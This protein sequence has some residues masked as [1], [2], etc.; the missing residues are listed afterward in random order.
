MI[1]RDENDR[2]QPR[3]EPA[4]TCAQPIDMVCGSVRPFRRSDWVMVGRYDFG[5]KRTEALD[6]VFPAHVINITTEGH[7]YFHGRSGRAQALP[8]TVTLGSCGD[9]YSC[10]H[11]RSH[12]NAN[13]VLA[14]S[15][16]AVDAD[17]GPIFERQVIEVPTLASIVHRALASDGDDEF[18]SRAFE[19]FDWVST[20]SQSPSKRRRKGVL[21]MQRVK[22]FLERNAFEDIRLDD[23]AGSV[24]L[25]PF[26]C[27]RQFKEAV[28]MTPHTYLM[29]CRAAEARRLLHSSNLLIEHIAARTG[30]KDHAYFCR[31]F[32][33]M[34][35]VTPSDY[36]R[37]SQR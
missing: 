3:R 28:G 31:F 7:W 4:G 34:T 21:R 15:G 9:S 16:D 24:G 19:I 25:N 12:A 27:L 17:V 22:R 30:F 26:V 37:Q 14:L 29:Q 33:R 11:D 13:L 18:D 36:R 35:G 2:N 6:K 10:G 5:R 23:I 8:G 20:I 1:Q 32:K